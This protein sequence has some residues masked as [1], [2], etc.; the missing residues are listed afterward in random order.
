M[1]WRR[2][3]T[4]FSIVALVGVAGVSAAGLRLR[5]NLE[6]EIRARAG[7]CAAATITE[8]QVAGGFL[9]QVVTLRSTSGLEADVALKRK[10]EASR[11]PVAILLGGLDTGRKAIDLVPDPG[12]VAVVALSY[13]F[14]GSR[15][16]DGLG[17]IVEVPAIQ[18]AIRDT[19]AAILLALDWVRV[20]PWADPDRI[21]LVGVS[22]GAPFA[23][24]A[25][26]LDPRFA[27]V[28]SLHGAGDP[29]LLLDHGLRKRIPWD[30]ARRV[31]ARA[32]AI[33]GYAD[34]IA[35]ER[36]VARIAPRP[37][38]MVNALDDQRLPRPAIDVLHEAAR[39]PKE[40]VWMP[41]KHV[42]PDRRKML[43]DLIGLVLA[44]MREPR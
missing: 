16:H 27:R 44:R 25:G 22:L 32:I 3:W 35:P 17:W 39:E 12:E 36:W 26:A 23:C 43:D 37:F 2:Y 9:V 11:R 41:G 31:A 20:Q 21:E 38:V 42:E 30:P 5:R 24:V 6:P 29:K 7:S 34:S 8:E 13:P 15:D 33:L 40:I 4:G 19:P 1:R 14:R 28:W 18:D 10:A